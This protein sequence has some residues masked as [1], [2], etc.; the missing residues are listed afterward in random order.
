VPRED[1]V[2]RIETERLV[3]RRARADDL[4]AMHAVLSDPTAMR[5][6]WT[7]P[8]ADLAQTREWLE[9]MIADSP[10]ERDDF[11]LEYEGRVVGKAGCWRVP[12]IG[13]ILH[14][15]VWGRGIASEA[16]AA[17]IPRL[18]DRF[19]VPA[20]TADVDP[21]NLPSLGL[22]KKL[23]FTE[24]GRASATWQIGDE[25]FDSIYLALPRPA[26][27]T[28]AAAGRGSLHAPLLR[29]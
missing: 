3:L 24:T 15:S 7:P 27:E 23:G 5:Y 26:G 4:G 28:G 8:H 16:L 29:R 10:S 17:I 14:P 18:F 22:L 1:G 2:E 11:I 13:F 6:W 9:S 25:L 19:P 20:I 21:R 12:Q